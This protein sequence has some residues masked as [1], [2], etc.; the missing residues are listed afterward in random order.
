[1]LL[2]CNLA[3]ANLTTS[4]RWRGWQQFGRR[5]DDGK[6]RLGQAHL[7][8]LGI[9][10]WQDAWVE[11]D[12]HAAYRDLAGAGELVASVRGAVWWDRF[13]GMGQLERVEAMAAGGVGRYSPGAVKLMLDGVCEN[14]TASLLDPYLPPAAGSGIDMIDPEELAGIVV[15]LDAA[16]LQ[17]HFHAIG[18]AAVRLALDAVEAARLANGW[19]DL[20]PTIAHIQVIHPDDVP[21][22]RRLGVIPNMQP[23]W[24]QADEAMTELTIPFL[25]EER[26]TWQYP[27]RSLAAAGATLA[28]G[29]DWPVST[30]GVLEQVAVAVTRRGPDPEM[31][32]FLPAEALDL[33]TVLRA[34]TAGSA[35][36]NHLS[37]DRGTI[38]PGTVADLVVLDGD[39]FVAGAVDEVGVDL[40]LV[41]GEVV[42]EGRR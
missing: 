12:L 13:G 31:D 7:L 42:Y 37:A 35:H 1:M 34:V 38:A 21:R 41:G 27:F 14:F 29:S 9:T 36:V 40:T 30:A 5:E 3:L 28:M 32:P 24:A 39:P 17:C 22:F 18:D 23:L 26:A 33:A 11:P 4:M 6:L 8:S 2:S 25:G 16:G 19:T 10:A 15:A 20:R